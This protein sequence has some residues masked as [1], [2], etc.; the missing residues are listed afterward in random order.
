M[1]KTLFIVRGLPG[2][3]KS[4]LGYLLAGD[5]SFAADDYFYDRDKNYNYDATKINT[6]HD[7][8]FNKVKEAMENGVDKIATCNTF[9]RKWEY[10]NYFAL[11]DKYGYTVHEIISKG[12][13][14]SIH[15]VPYNVVENMKERF[16][17]E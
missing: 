1:T 7:Y 13:F 17:Y 8:C 14:N 2:S 16:E 10:D 9:T 4:T 15:N 6:A 12:E 11:A 5:N 3:G